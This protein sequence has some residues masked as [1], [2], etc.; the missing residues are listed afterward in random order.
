[1]NFLGWKRFQEPI[2]PLITTERKVFR[3]SKVL[4]GHASLLVKLLFAIFAHPTTT[5]LQNDPS[6][7]MEWCSYIPTTMSKQSKTKSPF[8]TMNPL[9]KEMRIRLLMLLRRRDITV[10]RIKW[11]G[12]SKEVFLPPY[13]RHFWVNVTIYPPHLEL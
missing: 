3:R 5:H 4:P 10:I 12:A 2:F 11:Y 6:E 9:Q 7:D 13:S 1:M 8:Y